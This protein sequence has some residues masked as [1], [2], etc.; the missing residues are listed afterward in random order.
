[1][2]KITFDDF[3]NIMSFNISNVNC[4]EI[5]FSV[6]NSR[7]YRCSWLGKTQ[8]GKNGREIYWFGLTEDG[9]QAYDYE[10]FEQLSNARVFYGKSIKEIWDLVT[11]LSIDACSVE[12]RLPFYLEH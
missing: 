7:D 11:I 12:E 1:M 6:D 5:E 9:S 3:T 2:S 8:D 4:I 10:T